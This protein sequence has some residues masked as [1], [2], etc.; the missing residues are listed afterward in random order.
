MHAST[1]YIYIIFAVAYAIYS[2]VKA[3]K[4][5]TANRPNIDKQPEQSPTV[6]P[7]ASSPVPNQGDEMKKMLEDLFGGRQE[8]E[9]KIPEKEI[10]KP[11]PQPQHHPEKQR[12]PQPVSHHLEHAKATPH[13]F[14]KEK[15]QAT[16]AKPPAAKPQ[17]VLMKS[18]V[19]E[20]V[21][22]DFDIRQAII[23]S[24][25]LKRPEY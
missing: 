24:E 14:D 2:I 17:K 18:A 12:H 20:E 19:E 10:P 25:I 3:G 7:P 13:A 15:L 5:V 1:N 6:K 9:E 23:Y 16:H 4:K 8:A 11:K 21:E 22:A